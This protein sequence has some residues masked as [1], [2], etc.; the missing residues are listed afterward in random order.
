MKH[1]TVLAG[2]GLLLVAT[3]PGVR[4]ETAEPEVAVERVIFN[5]GCVEGAGGTCDSTSY[6]LSLEPG[7]Q[8]VGN[9]G[10]FTPLGYA[11]YTLDG[12]YTVDSYSADDTLR[13]SYV[14]DGGSTITG[15]I[16]IGG[17]VT[18]A[19][20]GVDSGV[21][22]AIRGAVEELRPNG[23]PRLVTKTL[24]QAE[25]TKTVSTPVD[26]VYEFEFVVPEELDQV[27]LQ[28]LSADV[29]QRHITVLQNGFVD[30]EGASY[31]D[32]PHVVPATTS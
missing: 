23:T 19:E 11:F 15:Q 28:R 13:E 8:S 10:S 16:T 7:V 5:T 3:A 30:G 27:A 26:T 4:A 32:L 9:T 29:G 20:L 24:G 6:T 2:L 18:G 25:I 12:E 31:F 21:L 14:L 17:Y 1:R 22:V